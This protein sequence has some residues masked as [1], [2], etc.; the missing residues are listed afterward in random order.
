MSISEAEHRVRD[1]VRLQLSL[2]KAG[3]VWEKLK[4]PQEWLDRAEVLAELDRLRANLDIA[5][6]QI[7]STDT[8]S[9]KLAKATE[10]LRFYADLDNWRG[11]ETGRL[12]PIVNDLGQVARVALRKI[13]S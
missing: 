6:E 9:A 4:P 2:Y 10:A 7:E 12:S 11:P 13:E 8:L 5:S 3:G 1:S